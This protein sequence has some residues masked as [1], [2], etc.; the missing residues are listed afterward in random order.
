MIV[1]LL[2]LVQAAQ[3]GTFKSPRLTESSG[4]AVSRAHRGVLWS[5][6]DSG[7]GPYLY[8]TDLA[9]TDRGALLVPGARAVD[10]EDM[11]LGPCPGGRSGD[12]LYF[13]DTGDNAE[14]RPTVTVYAV[15]E[16]EPPVSPADTQRTTPAP[17]VL[18]LRY[19]DGP[20]D[21]E[22][23]YVSFRDSALYYV[24]KGRSGAIRLYRV[25]AA[26]WRA[27]GDATV[28]ASLVQE[29]PIAPELSAGR[30]VT[31]AAMRPDG[32]L[33]AIR[34][35]G[36]IFFFT[37]GDAGRLTPAARPVCTVR[38]LESQ[39]EAIDFLDDTTVVLT[40]EAGR[41]APG[42]IHTVRCP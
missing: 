15:P 17:A 26:D 22:A 39:G 3:T 5:H 42:S 16:P 18:Q 35:Y 33:V 4:V 1:I 14:R 23:I 24:S 21:V 40:S 6:N 25:P 28:V 8:A 37:P 9:G 11:A 36:E 38:G 32:G 19:V 29:L 12:C 13:A 30:W 27:G 20:H 2:G 41:N 31:G 10:W 7:D 34:T